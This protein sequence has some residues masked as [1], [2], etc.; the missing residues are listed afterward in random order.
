MERNNQI[1]IRKWVINASIAL[2]IGL[3]VNE[4]VFYKGNAVDGFI[5]KWT[6]IAAGEFSKLFI[7]EMYEAKGSNGSF[8]IM[9]PSLRKVFVADD[10]NARSLILL[11]LGFLL[12]IPIGQ[13]KRKVQ[14][15]LLGTIAIVVFNIL[16]IAILFMLAAK[17]PDFFKIMHKYFFQMSIYL[18]MFYLWRLYVKIDLRERLNAINK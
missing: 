6:S 15:I 18:L 16:R 5:T 3:L 2:F 9:S 17:M 11:Y 13:P 14:F 10:C 7:D 12:A 1:L 4:F 8:C